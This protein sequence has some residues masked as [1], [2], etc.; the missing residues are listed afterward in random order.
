MNIR[1]I[2]TKRG[3]KKAL[4]RIEALLTAV[5][6]TEKGDELDVLAT[7]VDVYESKLIEIQG[8]A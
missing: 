1:P 3:Y 2:K 5:P 8:V 7:R 6:G 4:R